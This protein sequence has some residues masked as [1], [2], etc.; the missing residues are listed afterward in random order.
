[1]VESE[2]L[3]SSEDGSDRA[4]IGLKLGAI[5]TDEV[6]I[7]VL[8]QDET[9]GLALVESEEFSDE[10]GYHRPRSVLNFDSSNWNAWQ[11]V[12]IQGVD[13]QIDDDDQTYTLTFDASGSADSN[14]QVLTEAALLREE[15]KVEITNGDDDTAGISVIGLPEETEEGE[16]YTFE[17]SLDSEPTSEVE[18]V[19]TSNDMTEG[20]VNPGNLSYT[21]ENYSTPQR[22]V[23][24][25]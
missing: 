12:Q 23:Q 4:R 20:V 8:L 1:M 6:T 11:Y 16:E 13:D 17:V 7:E 2:D 21:P 3:T 25:Q 10:Y 22:A 5:P 15:V 9:E 19:L 24:R 14:Y 18:V